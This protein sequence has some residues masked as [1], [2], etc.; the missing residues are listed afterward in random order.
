M[1]EKCST[2]AAEMK[3]WAL[4]IL[5]I[6]ACGYSFA[7]R[8]VTLRNG[9]SV[10]GDIVVQNEEVLILKT[11]EGARF[12]YPAAEVVSV[13]EYVEEAE[14]SVEEQQVSSRRVMF[15][16][17]LSGGGTVIPQEGSG[18]HV[19]GELLVGSREIGG[20]RIFAG[21]GIGVHG[22]FANGSGYTFLPLQAA[23]RVP[24]LDGKHAPYIGAAIGYG[25]GVSKNCTGGIYTGG[26][27]GYMY[28]FG[29]YSA[30]FVSGRVQFQQAKIAAMETI[31]ADDGTERVFVNQSGRSFVTIGL[32][33][34][35]SF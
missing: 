8:V 9:K 4:L 21:G 10:R 17:G 3:K 24:F 29:R 35:I 20:K 23:L 6:G 14:V 22:L 34:G 32:S 18:G 1:L 15:I 11:A 31:T 33:A 27:V 19:G 7:E 30:F 12:Q 16:L 25:F 28:Q 2:F 5:L 26:E 13:R